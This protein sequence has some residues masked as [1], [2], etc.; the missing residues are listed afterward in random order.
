MKNY[1]YVLIILLCSCSKTV[2]VTV[3]SNV[4]SGPSTIIFDNK[5]TLITGKSID[6]IYLSSYKLHTFT[7]NHGGPQEFRLNNKGGILN[8]ARKEFIVLQA[9]FE[10]EGGKRNDFEF[11]MRQESYVLIDS[12]IVCKK[13]FEITDQT[14]LKTIVNYIR[15][16]KNG[17]YKPPL[18]KRSPEEI[19]KYDVSESVNYFKKIGNKELFIEQ[20]WDY[21]LG[22]S[23]PDSIQVLV[24]KRDLKYKNTVN[25]TFVTFADN[26]LLLA[27]MSKKDYY[28]V[29]VRDLLKDKI[30]NTTKLK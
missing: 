8:L 26:F 13:A 29:D 6:S 9:G 4:T 30:A 18:D 2:K 23:I 5:D 24:S 27:R 3:I 10:N 11:E 14:K 21:N 15:F 19:E 28:V 17:N 16:R 25:K 22:D 7:V 20:F 12:F 1:F